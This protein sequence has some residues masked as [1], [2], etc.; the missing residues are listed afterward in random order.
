MLAI[1]A[2]ALLGLV[3]RLWGRSGIHVLPGILHN[4]LICVVL[5]IVS[6]GH[7][8]FTSETVSQPWFPYSA[9]L[10]LCFIGGFYLFG[11]AVDL[12]GVAIMSAVQK[13]SLL[14][15]ISFIVLYFHERPDGIQWMAMGLGITS[16][17]FLVSYEKGENK[18][19]RGKWT[20]G[21]FMAGGSL[22]V[23]GFIE[24]GLMVLEKEVLLTSGDPHFLTQLFA[25]AFLWGS[26]PMLALQR[27]RRAFWTIRHF[28]AGAI[29][30]L[31]NFGS[32]F[33]LMKSL[34]SSQSLSLVLPVINVG[35]L[36]AAVGLGRFVLNEP[37]TRR[38][39]AGI[40]MAIVSI[41]VLSLNHWDGR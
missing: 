21:L 19:I 9:L 37:L 10:S 16:L 13:M 36:L 7:W 35:T 22:L 5:G 17:P 39:A 20:K 23:A 6:S 24:A 33:F 3:F 30:G 26:I 38:H 2:N 31:I 27:Q 4:Y 8:P 18:R 32:I 1:V 14:V 25:F 41:L 29:L 15:S 40:I 11:L 34:G 28:Q 12:W